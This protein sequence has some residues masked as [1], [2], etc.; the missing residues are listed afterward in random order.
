[1]ESI[2]IQNKR[3]K[4]TIN[5]A[6]NDNI[7]K[8]KS[9]TKFWQRQQE[10]NPSLY[11]GDAFLLSDSDYVKNEQEIIF[12]VYQTEY[13]NYL[14]NLKMENGSRN[15]ISTT[16]IVT[17]DDYLVLGGGK[18]GESEGMLHFIGGAHDI[19]DIEAN[20]INTKKAMERMLFEQLP[21]RYTDVKSS[22][23]LLLVK[24]ATGEVSIIYLTHLTITKDNLEAVHQTMKIKEFQSLYCLALEQKTLIEFTFSDGEYAPYVKSGI[25][26]FYKALIIKE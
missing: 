21:I 18:T 17:A 7:N 12:D 16:I 5:E 25:E 9:I 10:L 11:N 23:P 4:I 14:Y 20:E 3:V 26:A 6:P 22:Q 1:M 19:A 15:I 2:N 8:V 13:M 24:S